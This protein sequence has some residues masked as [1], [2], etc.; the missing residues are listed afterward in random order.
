LTA[1][2]FR[3]TN[4]GDT[5]GT[6][7]DTEKIDFNNTSSGV[8]DSTGRLIYPSLEMPRNINFHPNPRKPQNKIQDALLSLTRVTLTGYFINHANTLGPTNLHNWQIDEAVTDDFPFGRFGLLLT[9]SVNSVMTLTPTTTQ[10]YILENFKVMDV[11]SPRTEVQ[12]I[13]YLL[14]NGTPT[15]ISLPTQE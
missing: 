8:P 10:G 7:A 9:E 6:L 1:T 11:E 13:I 3:F 5:I 14:R 15:T 2:L 12:F 4:S